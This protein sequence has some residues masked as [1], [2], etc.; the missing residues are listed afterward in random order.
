MKTLLVLLAL[1]VLSG[2]IETCIFFSQ[3][4][5]IKNAWGVPNIQ[6]L[7]SNQGEAR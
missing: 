3:E 4:P 1:L 6:A 2:C 5:E 7:K